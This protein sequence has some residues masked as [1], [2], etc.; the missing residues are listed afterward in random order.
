VLSVA[1]RNRL[2]TVFENF[3]PMMAYWICPWI[4]I[5][6]EEHLLFHKLTG[7]A[8]DC[9]IYESKSKLPIGLA[10]LLSFLIGFPGAIV[11]MYQIWYTGPLALRVGGEYGGDIGEGSQSALRVSCSRR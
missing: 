4:T 5:V 7:K 2:F 6:L 10:A 8:F 1:G 9:S 11:G 3:L